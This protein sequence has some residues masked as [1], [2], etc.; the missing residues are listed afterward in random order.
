MIPEIQKY[1][2]LYFIRFFADAFF[3]PFYSMFLATI[4]FDGTTIGFIMSILTFMSMVAN[5]LWS[6]LAKNV[7]LSRKYLLVMVIAESIGIIVLTGTAHLGVVIIALLTVVIGLFNNPTYGL[8]D[9]MT[10]TYLFQ[11]RHDFTSIRVFGSIGYAIGTIFGGIIFTS[12][13][14]L[15][16]SIIAAILTFSVSLILLALKEIK[17]EEE[18]EEGEKKSNLKQ[19][20]TNKKY[21]A[22]LLSYILFYGA[23]AVG[24]VYF[25]LYLTSK[26]YANLVGYILASMFVVE[27]FCMIFINFKLKKVK[28]THLI[29]CFLIL[30]L[31]RCLSIYFSFGFFSVII[32]VLCRGVGIS[33][34]VTSNVRYISKITRKNNFTIA[35]MSL[36]VASSI[37]GIIFNIFGGYLY[38]T[39]SFEL[40]YL[41]LA[42]MGVIGGISFIL[43]NHNS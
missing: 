7:S 34:V 28:S 25:S 20:L 42:G 24:D 4:L 30:N 27:I 13:G 26:N 19:L 40:L 38:Q 9:G 32:A 41:V 1:R 17:V 36:T 12:F 14:F 2:I 5:P 23:F 37:F 29:Y 33:V 3:Y 10:A 11:D 35:L 22:Y 18:V 16:N 43:T 8:I 39:Y 31:I 15:I 21:I 6:L